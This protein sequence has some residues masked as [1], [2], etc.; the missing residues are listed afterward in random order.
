MATVFH[1]Y[2]NIETINIYQ[3]I[4]LNSTDWVKFDHKIHLI[5]PTDVRCACIESFTH[6]QAKIF[7]AA[8]ATVQKNSSNSVFGVHVSVVVHENKCVSLFV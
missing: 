3:G 7:V 5:N 8:A 1:S 2:R 4:L 6:I